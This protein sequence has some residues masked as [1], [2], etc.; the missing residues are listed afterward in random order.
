MRPFLPLLFALLT[1]PAHAASVIVEKTITG[2]NS[3]ESVVVSGDDVFVSNVGV[4]LEPFAKDGDGYIAKLD[5]QG[6]IKAL[7]WVDQLDAPKGMIAVNG[8]LYVADIDRVLGFRQRDG[9]R[10]F[11][12]DLAASGAKFLNSFARYDNRR[13]L[14]SSTDLGKVFIIDLP[15]RGYSELK[16]DIPPN[17]PNGLKKL[18]GRLIVVEWGSDNQANGKVKSYLLDG[19]TA[20]LEKTWE[21]SPAGYFDGVV[22]LGANR[23]LIS[24]WVKFEPAGLLHVLD[25]HSGKISTANPNTPLAGPADLFLDDQGK[26]WVPGMM[27]GKVYRMSVRH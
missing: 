8:V 5:R 19:F 11:E 21:P 18:G 12:L 4:K 22:S 15:G 1:L 6:N 14:L 16:F 10:V 9:K 17:G 20:K 13:L 23:W 24:N 25:S 27:E 2:F 3:P 7:K 26:L